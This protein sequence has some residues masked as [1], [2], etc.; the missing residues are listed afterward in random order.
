MT[1]KTALAPSPELIALCRESIELWGADFQLDMVIE[2]CA[3]LIKAIQK[4]R[5]EGGAA[6]IVEEAVD[7]Y[8]MIAQIHTIFPIYSWEAYSN[9]KLERLKKRIEERRAALAG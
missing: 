8:H 6:P 3:E 7:V 5:R 1:A 2:E 9:Q 4:Y